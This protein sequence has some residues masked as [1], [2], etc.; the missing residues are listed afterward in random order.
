MTE[1]EKHGKFELADLKQ[2]HLEAFL[3]AMK[4]V[5]KDLPLQVYHGKVLKAALDAGW[6]VEPKVEDVGD[7]K[8][9]K[10]RWMAEQLISAYSEA[11]TVDPN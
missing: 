7:L 11:V 4:D 1:H 9:A 5:D 2:R 8:P 6:I 3:M 10:V